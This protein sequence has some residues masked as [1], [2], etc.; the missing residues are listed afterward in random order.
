MHCFNKKLYLTTSF[1]TFFNLLSNFLMHH[2][3]T[4]QQFEK[5]RTTKIIF[6]VLRFTPN[7]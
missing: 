4:T 3:K 6:I 1:E 2:F 5:E 7:L